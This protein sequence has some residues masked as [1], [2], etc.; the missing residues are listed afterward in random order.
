MRGVGRWSRGLLA[1][2]L[3]VVATLA[4]AALDFTARAETPWRHGLSAFDKLKYG[5]DFTHL[6]YVNPDAPKGGTLSMIGDGGRVTFDSFNGFILKGDAAQ[7]L[8]YLFDT[9]MVR[10]FDE[11]DAVYG[12]VAESAAVAADGLSVTFKLRAAARFA[13]GSP[14]TADDV[15]FSFHALKDKGHPSYRIALRDVVSSEAIDAATV[16]YTFK[17][18]LVRDLPMTVAGLPILSKA[19]YA[20]RPFEETSLEPPLGS[21]PYAIGGFKPGTFVAYHRR[22]DYWAR[23]LP[24]VRGHYNFD[25]LR[26][27]YY[28]DR[29]AELENLKNGT[30]DLREEFTSVDWATAYNIPAVRDGRLKRV[31]LPD[32]RP[33][34]AQGFFINT[35]KDKFKDPRVRK[36]LDYAFDFQWTNDNLF[37]KLYQRTESFFE[38]SDMK[39]EGLPGPDELALLEPY[40]DRL[41]AEVF[42]PAYRPPTSNGSGS[43]RTLLR[44]VDR[45]LSEAGFRLDQGRRV[46]AKGEQL[47]IEF[48]L[49]AENFVR[50]IGPYAENLKRLGIDATIR[51]VDPAQYERRVKSFDFDVT[52][53]RYVMRLTPGSE[54]L[55]FWGS[56]VA[57]TEGSFNLAG[58][59]DPVVDALVAKAMSAKTRADLV[60]AT[61]ALDRVLRAGHYWVPHWY[62]AAHH[63]AFWDKFSW[64]AT[65][66]KFDRGIIATW[67]YD[68]AK[69][70]RLK[71][72]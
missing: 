58:I 22:A 43:D 8:D 50:I 71:G 69:A 37:Y 68:E 28:R 31:V 2:G 49:F 10:A 16:R 54:M 13:D 14:V 72:P 1:G 5:P 66:P 64:P 44:E 15:V 17:G 24:I 11:P 6:D 41:P 32:D 42:G 33:S 38:N 18:E 36:A 48:L 53:Q 52:T 34:G 62:K 7:G 67:W 3:A 39:A 63:L 35:R 21:G 29:T 51:L 47:T 27:E 20:V 40:R 57:K 4:I 9:L 65:K 25:V 59:S 46:D 61:R 55:G 23:D 26:Y 60:T 56:E 12:L 19:W 70:A 30:F 45:L